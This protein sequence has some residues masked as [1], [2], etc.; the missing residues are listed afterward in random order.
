MVNRSDVSVHKTSDSH[1]ESEQLTKERRERRHR[2]GLTAVL[3]VIVAIVIGSMVL[4][5]YAY[6][7]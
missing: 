3:V 2:I 1:R 5:Y 4:N 7:K 6:R